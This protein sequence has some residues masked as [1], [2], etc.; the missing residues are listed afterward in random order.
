MNWTRMGWLTTAV[1]YSE[2]DSEPV[3][4]TSA[5][6]KICAAKVRR[7]VGHFLRLSCVKFPCQRRPREK[8]HRPRPRAF[9][10]STSFSICSCVMAASPNHEDTLFIDVSTKIISAC[11][12]KRERSRA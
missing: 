7:G 5:S 8:A 1:M 3:P 6:S 12:R 10:S 4:L 2:Y 11:V 9:A